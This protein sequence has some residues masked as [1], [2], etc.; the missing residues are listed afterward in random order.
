MAQIKS[1]VDLENYDEITAFAGADPERVVRSYVVTEESGNLAAQ[2]FTDLA[3]PRGSAPAIQFISGRR[4]SGKS[5][6]LAFVRSLISH[7][8]LRSIL[9]HAPLQKALNQPGSKTLIP[10]ELNFTAGDEQPSFEAALRSAINSALVEGAALDDER[11]QQAVEHGLIFEQ[12]FS[13]LPLNAELVLFLDGMSSR[14]R[15]APQLFEADATWLKI[16][17][18]QAE[19]LSLRVIIALEEKDFPSRLEKFCLSS[20]PPAATIREVSPAVLRGVIARSVLRK[21]PDAKRKLAELYRQLKQG[22]P[23]FSW[24]EDEFIDYY[25]VHPALETLSPA[26][27]LHS[28]SFSLPGFAATAASRALNRPELSLVAV[29]ELFNRYEYELRKAEATAPVFALYDHINA[30]ALNHLTGEDRL[31]AKMLAKALSIFLLTESPVNVRTLADS[32]LLAEGSSASESGYERAARILSHFESGAPENILLTGEGLDRAWQFQAAPPPVPLREQLAATADQIAAD[33]LR[34]A[35]LLVT[36]GARVFA[37]WNLNAAADNSHD[38]ASTELLNALPP[39]SAFR[40]VMWRGT[41]RRGQISLTQAELLKSASALHSKRESNPLNPGTDP[42]PHSSPPATEPEWRLL[43]VPFNC[44][45]GFDTPPPNSLDLHWHPGVA[46]SEEMLLPLRLLLALHERTTVSKTTEDEDGNTASQSGRQTRAVASADD[47]AEI[48]AVMIELHEQIK[49]LFADL[50][51]ARGTFVDHTGPRPMA[52]EDHQSLGFADLLNR[53]VRTTLDSYYPDHPHFEDGFNSEHVSELL[54]GLFASSS[55]SH[56][57]TRE[58]AAKFAAPLGLVS[59]SR[60]KYRLNVFNEA[61]NLPP[62]IHALVTLVEIHADAE[63]RSDVPL[64][65]VV[66]LLGV[67]PYGLQLAAQHLILVAFISSGVYELVDEATGKRLTKS[68]LHLGFEPS[69]FTTLRRVAT[70]DYPLE[71]LHSW[72]KCLTGRNDLPPMVSPDARQTVRDALAEWLELWREQ[73][74]RERFEEVPADLMTMNTWHTVNMSIR[75]QERTAAIVESLLED[76]LTI[77]TGLSRILDLFGLDIA[78]LEQTGLKMQALAGFLDW[79]PTFI[80][81][82]N[83]LLAA[84]TTGEEKIDSEWEQLNLRLREPHELLMSEAR[85]QLE[86]SFEDFRE[87]YSGFYAQAHEASVGLR[88]YREMVE[89]FYASEDWR[90]FKLLTQ[91]KLDGRAFESDA[92]M[93]TELIDKTRCELPISEILQRQPH[94]GCSFR[95]NRRLHLGSVLDAFRSMTK[96][97][98]TYY[99]EEMW[100]RRDEIRQYLRARESDPVAT[101]INDF[102]T[103]CGEGCVVNLSQEVVNFLNAHL[104]DPPLVAVLPEMPRFDDGSFTKEQLRDNLIRWVDSL[105][106]ENGLLFRVERA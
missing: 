5:H 46:T 41:A 38:F 90:T 91:L 13:V 29:D 18:K 84:E 44:G 61:A 31:W 49:A 60:G 73:N 1:Y 39:A 14:W 56:E 94:C 3:A 68:N 52:L 27:R 26:L 97:A 98:M 100:E 95:L 15:I 4:G 72:S 83:Y 85:I 42:N 11:W 79:L 76:A 70:T 57:Q 53:E 21:K 48:A 47:P 9:N 36:I 86:Q 103:G 101:T 65:K 25:P 69:R 58:L 55:S 67:S 106:P 105:P 63:G 22:L 50:Y 64:L 17:L 34:L 10:V 32:M 19:S 99:C 104:P 89:S 62:F 16:I 6:L 93:L 40:E 82:R 8:S 45:M 102:V 88:G 35:S 2:I 33:D 59:E 74:L 66:R 80:N 30:E 12:T 7:R 81:L 43:I 28:R 24:S 92:R 20:E 75:R 51:L 37:D 87:V 71:I 23:A 96:S 77:E 54:T 78:A